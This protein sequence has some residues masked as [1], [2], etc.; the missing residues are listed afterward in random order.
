[1]SNT[2][3][4]MSTDSNTPADFDARRAGTY[5]TAYALQSGDLT[6]EHSARPWASVGY[7][8]VEAAY[9][10]VDSV[11]QHAD[12]ISPCGGYAWH[13]WALREAFLAGCTHHRENGGYI[14]PTVEEVTASPYAIELDETTAQV[15]TCPE[16]SSTSVGLSPWPLGARAHS[17]RRGSIEAEIFAFDFRCEDCGEQWKLQVEACTG[18]RGQALSLTLEITPKPPCIL[19]FRFVTPSTPSRTLTGLFKRFFGESKAA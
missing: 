9:R 8:E 2:K 10:Y 17:E 11:V 3:H 15:L 7:P 16:C 18:Q 6:P 12:A 1:L 14:V 5:A 13:G 19:P 4:A